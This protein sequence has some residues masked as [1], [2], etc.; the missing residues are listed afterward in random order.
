MVRINAAQR[1]ESMICT[2]I[3]NITGLNY[4]TVCGAMVEFNEYGTLPR[5]RALCPICGSLERHRLMNLVL[6]SCTGQDYCSVFYIGRE[7]KSAELCSNY[8]K[9]DSI[10]V[11]EG[12]DIVGEIK[13]NG[14]T[15]F[16]LIVCD[17]LFAHVNNQM[18]ILE[19]LKSRLKKGGVIVIGG[20]K[21]NISSSLDEKSVGY[22][23][24]SIN[25]FN[26]LSIESLV[27]DLKIKI[28][29]TLGSNSIS[30]EQQK[31]Y[32]TRGN[33]IIYVITA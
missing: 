31:T 21:N 20:F 15:L 9:V 1:R 27:L 32:S 26:D 19:I 10:I 6:D 3:T 30:E 4:C 2:L 18:H 16:D 22:A 17:D 24:N 25:C 33:Y 29:T 23:I 7:K 28:N 12:M 14:N 11:I 5:S 8:G 13:N